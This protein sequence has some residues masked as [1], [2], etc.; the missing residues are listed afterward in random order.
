MNASDTKLMTQPLWVYI[1]CWLFFLYLYIQLLSFSVVNP[2]NLLLSGLQFID[3]GVHE[4]SHLIVFFLPS[5]LVAA[6]GSIGEIG[7]TILILIATL[8]AK[9]YFA[10][11]FACLWIMLAMHSVGHY[12]AD[13]RA[14]AIPLV[15]PGETVKH[16]WNYVF[17][18]LGW[19]HY[20]TAIGGA[21]SAIG[22]A[23]GILALGFGLYLIVKKVYGNSPDKAG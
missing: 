22:S 23:I 14:Q 20:D 11:I 1:G 8:K 10:C 19:L 3:F 12:M 18:Q 9:A 15:G 7:F 6:A 2:N 21:F 4:V 5:I 13:A 16:D 17:S